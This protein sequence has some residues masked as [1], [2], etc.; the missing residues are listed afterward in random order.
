MS[1]TVVGYHAPKGFKDAIVK[2]Q[3]VFDEF[4]RDQHGMLKQGGSDTLVGR[5]SAPLPRE[6]LHQIFEYLFPQSREKRRPR[7]RILYSP[8]P[9]E[10]ERRKAATD[11]EDSR[12][13]KWQMEPPSAALFPL[14]CAAA[15]HNWQRALSMEA[16]YW[17]RI[18]IFVDEPL[19]PGTFSPLFFA[20]SRDEIIDV[21]ITRRRFYDRNLYPDDAH[22]KDRVE[23]IMMHLRPH[24]HRCRTIRLDA[25]CRSSVVAALN[26]LKGDPPRLCILALC[27]EV[28]DTVDDADGLQDLICPNLT[29]LHID[30][31]SL[32]DLVQR[33]FDWSPEEGN[34][35][36]SYLILCPYQ[37]L[38]PQHG[39]LAVDLIRCLANIQNI[40]SISLRSIFF[41]PDF[42][43]P[44]V[45][46]HESDI[47]GDTLEMDNIP[48]DAVNALLK[49]SNT[50]NAH[51][52]NCSFSSPVLW[53]SSGPFNVTFGIAMFFNLMM[54]TKTERANVSGT[55]DQRTGRRTIQS[56][57]MYVQ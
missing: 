13:W 57:Y 20:W 52:K 14:S 34:R 23:Y 5:P 21:R 32:I 43:L 3:A 54:V 10:V 53:P 18:V 26:H 30:A 44:Q 45:T 33:G 49:F 29:N 24:L 2:A 6:V 28:A 39:V 7:R 16:A 35:R 55:K 40:D 56:S 22:E 25:K 31:K 9:E 8:Q 46:N 41:H 15:F 42:I 37:P 47:F 51:L 17:T 11:P 36:Y 19:T 50:E 1:S 38:D 27:S 12:W 4:R 48:F